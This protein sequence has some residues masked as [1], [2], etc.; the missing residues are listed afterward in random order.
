MQ[1]RRA[2]RRRSVQRGALGSCEVPVGPFCIAAVA[3]DP[4][5]GQGKL[6]VGLDVGFFAPRQ[7]SLEGFD[8]PGSDVVVPVAQQD[9]A[10]PVEVAGAPGALERFARVTVTVVPGGG[11]VEQL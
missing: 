4:S 3:R 2:V 9:T 5:C 6:R 11:T 8:P 10:C 1:G 7:P